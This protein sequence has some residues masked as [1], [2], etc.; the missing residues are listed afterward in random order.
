MKFPYS[1]VFI[2]ALLHA[3]VAAA[4]TGGSSVLGENWELRSPQGT[5][6]NLTAIAVNGTTNMVAV[7]EGGAIIK[8]TAP[9]TWTSQNIVIKTPPLVDT[10]KV[11]ADL[12]DVIWSDAQDQYVAV[13]SGGTIL[14]SADSAAWV[15]QDAPTPAT[16]R[17]NA[18]VSTT[19]VDL[20]AVGGSTANAGVILRSGDKGATWSRFVVPGATTFKDVVYTGSKYIAVCSGKVFTSATGAAPWVATPLAGTVPTSIAYVPGA[21]AVGTGTVVILGNKSWSSTNGGPWTAITAPSADLVVNAV[22]NELVGANKDGEVWASTDAGKTWQIRL[23]AQLIQLNA[24]SKMGDAYVVVGESGVVESS[25]GTLADALQKQIPSVTA[26]HLTSVATN[27]TGGAVTVGAGGKIFSAAA[28]DTWNTSITSPVAADL[29]KVIWTGTQ[30]V[31]VGSAGSLITS[32][33]GTDWTLR[34]PP[35][36]TDKFTGVAWNGTKLLAVGENTAHKGIS[37]TSTDGVAWTAV[38]MSVTLGSKALAIPSLLDV[39]AQGTSFV[40]IANGYALRSTEGSQWTAYALPGSVPVKV[41]ASATKVIITGNKNWSS[42]NGSAWTAL[43][44]PAVMTIDRVGSSFVGVTVTGAVWTSTD[45]GG[46]WYPLADAEAAGS[47]LTASTLLAD[48]HYVFVGKNGLIETFKTALAWDPFSAEANGV[49]WN[50]KSKAL[51]LYVAVGW[52]VSWTGTTTSTDGE[53]GKITWVPHR[54]RV[55][56]QP[57][58]GV[59]VLWS[60]TQFVA[61]GTSIWTS[62]DGIAWTERQHGPSTDPSVYSVAKMGGRIY[63]F[64]YDSA[65]LQVMV[66]IGDGDGNN[67]TSFVDMPGHRWAILSATQVLAQIDANTVLSYYLAVGWGGR[68]L[69]S[70]TGEPDSWSEGIV[71]G[72]SN[73]DFT[74]VTYSA[75]APYPVATTVNGAIWTL[76]ITKDYHLKWTRATIWSRNAQNIWVKTPGSLASHSLWCVQRSKQEFV[77]AGNYGFILKSFN[78]LDWREYPPDATDGATTPKNIGLQS[79]QHINALLYASEDRGDLLVAVGGVSTFLSSDGALDPVQPTIIF[80]SSPSSISEHNGSTTVTATLSNVLYPVPLTV[81]L[82]L[83]HVNL[84]NV[85]YKASATSLSFKAGELTKSFTLTT[86]DNTIADDND[87]VTVSSNV[88]AADFRTVA[89][90]VV[91]N[92]DEPE[93][94][95]DTDASTLTEG[96]P[97]LTTTDGPKVSVTITVSMATAPTTDVV[98]PLDYSASTV[99]STRYATTAPS[100]VTI[101][102][103]TLSKSF[104][105][106][107]VDDGFATDNSKKVIVK[108]WGVLDAN[109][110]AKHVHTVSFADNDTAPTIATQ[111]ASQ[112]V[113]LGSQVTFSASAEGS[114][115]NN[116]PQ[117][118]K[119]HWLKNDVAVTDQPTAAYADGATS[120]YSVTATLNSAG[121][122]KFETTDPGVTTSTGA[123]LAVI[124]TAPQTA[125]VKAEGSVTIGVIGAAPDSDSLTFQWFRNGVALSGKTLSQLN[126]VNETENHA[127]YTCTVSMGAL[128]LDTGDIFVDIVTSKPVVTPPVLGSAAVGADFSFTAR[129]VPA[130]SRWTITGLPTGLSY[131]NLTGLITGRPAKAGSFPITFVATNVVGNS[132]AVRATLVVT[133]LPANGAGTFMCVI[134]GDG[135]VTN[136]SGGR[137]DLTTTTAGTFTG[138]LTESGIV[139]LFSGN[140]GGV[141]GSS[142]RTAIVYLG[143]KTIS[144][145]LDAVQGTITGTVARGSD[146]IALKGWRQAAPTT[147]ISGYYTCALGG[148]DQTA[149]FGY[150]LVTIGTTGIVTITGKLAD[151]AATVYTLSTITGP[152][153]KIGVY[154]SLY[155]NTG[156]IVGEVD[157]TKGTAPAY[158]NN[159]MGGQVFWFVQPAV[160]NLLT[161]DGGRYIKPASG[162]RVLGLAATTSNAKLAFTGVDLMAVPDKSPDGLF[163]VKAVPANV[164]TAPAINP[165]STALGFTPDKGEFYGQ[166]SDLFGSGDPRNADFYGVMIRPAGSAAMVGTGFFRVG[167]FTG[168]V[169]LT[170]AP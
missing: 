15:K 68:Y 49:A 21:G 167:T 111:P 22:G 99:S 150:G 159:A 39:T 27:G 160:S 165:A 93:A 6:Q 47:P 89:G 141:A 43:S 125:T 29:A 170:K 86:I 64:G 26:Q 126:V 31:A 109:S 67:W 88:I 132:T 63:A 119:G 140:L 120:T 46:N 133:A 113:P 94:T 83:T 131:N 156:S 35:N 51:A 163:T 161:V 84:L 128:T 71:P 23:S 40:A 168:S 166:F 104:T 147:A 61:V 124:N 97:E 59:A 28:F 90:A 20:L 78:G 123:K 54:Q 153:G 32:P 2:M 56:N 25:T 95:F 18:V 92:D 149:G 114:K 130:A 76:A 13:G 38:T 145:T 50:G 70:V 102:A 14:T 77:A 144:L 73:D 65:R 80:A 37:A 12:L 105:I 19:A 158:T 157:I 79:P 53:Q 110:T 164:A 117:G 152:T 103:G 154:T 137:V 36:P 75:N 112:L 62:T 127:K 3:G 116:I 10:V 8:A 129:A 115:V 82:S 142:T 138:K 134:N 33:N 74:S 81:P 42:T 45:D 44:L 100:S 162:Q 143:N 5:S 85:R 11:T 155:T 60:G 55:N 30:Y 122:Y 1:L 169:S 48:G 107:A 57:F 96:A 69:T 4:Q 41:A 16:D 101:L 24:V 108:L 34:T 118:F 136:Y 106:T 135:V 72:G 148:L 17:L 139:T 7:G 121:T 146:T 98:V 66:S 87:V 151:S 9:G 52:D 58:S 91:I